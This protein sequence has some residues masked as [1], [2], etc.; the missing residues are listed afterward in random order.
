MPVA[1]ADRRLVVQLVD[2]RQARREVVLVR[3]VE[4]VSVRAERVVFDEEGLGLLV[5]LL[6]DG[7][8]VVAQPQ[9][10]RQPAADAP[11]VLHEAD[12]VV[13]LRR[14]DAASRGTPPPASAGCR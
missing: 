6:D 8:E 12:Q 4:V 1:G 11:R 9:L 5:L 3:V 2:R 14:E 10:E 7:V 13:L